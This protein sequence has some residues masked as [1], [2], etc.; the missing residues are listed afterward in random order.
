MSVEATLTRPVSNVDPFSHGFLFD[1]Y[2]HHEA[3]REAGP[4][5]WLEEYGV[6]AMARHEQVREALTDWQTY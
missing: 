6:W 3:L 5:V 2:P 4:V 1:P